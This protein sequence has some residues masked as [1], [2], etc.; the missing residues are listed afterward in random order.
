MNVSA[1]GTMIAALLLGAALRV[2]IPYLRTGLELVAESGSFASWPV[3]D[4]R[5]LAMFLLPVL[6]FTVAFL[7][8]D[9]LWHAAQEWRFVPTLAMSY[10][11]TDIGRDVVG[12]AVAGVK[13]RAR[14]R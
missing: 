13:L 7:T 5:Y 14:A 3:F 9:G 2:G 11:G 4:A 12:V 10:A 1:M 6:G 8:V